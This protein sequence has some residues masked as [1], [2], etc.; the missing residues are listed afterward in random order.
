MTA[1]DFRALS[2]MLATGY[3]EAALR[4]AAA[5]MLLVSQRLLRGEAAIRRELAGGDRNS[6]ALGDLA[7]LLDALAP[8]YNPT[9]EAQTHAR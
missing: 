9:T 2:R 8:L 7:I 5:A 3:D 6:L 4:E 1:P